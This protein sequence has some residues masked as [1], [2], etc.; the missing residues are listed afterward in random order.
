MV[1]L[2]L[3]EAI[4]FVIFAIAGFVIGWRI[5]AHAAAERMRVLESDIDS[6]RHAWSDAQARRASRSP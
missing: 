4:L 1:G 3:S 6:L 2:F 5:E